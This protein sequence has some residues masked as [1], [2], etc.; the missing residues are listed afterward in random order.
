MQ[1]YSALALQNSKMTVVFIQH[2]SLTLWTKTHRIIN[3]A[4]LKSKVQILRVNAP[5]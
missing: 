2:D 1:S 3:K 4:D 5:T